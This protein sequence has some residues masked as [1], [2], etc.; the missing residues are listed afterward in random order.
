MMP[1][2]SRNW[3]RTS[4]TTEPAALADRRHAHAAEQ[5]RD[6]AAEQQADDDVGVGER[7]IDGHA[8]EVL[9]G[10]RARLVRLGDEEVEV[11]GVGGEQH[12]RAE[13]GRADR[14]ALGDGLGGVA[15]RVERVGRLADFRRQAGHLGDAAGIVGDRA[16]R[17][18]RHDDAGERQHG[19]RR[20]GDAEQ[21]GEASR[22]R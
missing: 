18:E 13:T 2:F 3:R 22:R 21:A 15:D 9:E 17:V 4:S 12:Q 11:G 19:G 5:E 8:L 20:D 16:E 10:G 1:G 6:Q 14:V 7:E